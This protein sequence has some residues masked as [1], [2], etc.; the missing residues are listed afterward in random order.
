MFVRVRNIGLVDRSLPTPFSTSVL[1]EPNELAEF[2]WNKADLNQVM[3]L[4][5]CDFTVETITQVKDIFVKDQSLNLDEVIPVIEECEALLIGTFV[6]DDFGIHVNNEDQWTD[7]ESFNALHDAYEA[8]IDKLINATSQ[9]E[10]SE[11]KTELETAKD[12]VELLPGLI[13][14]NPEIS[15]DAATEVFESAELEKSRTVVSETGDDLDDCRSAYWATKDA[16]DTLNDALKTAVTS[17]S[18]ASDQSA[19]DS[20][21]S[22]LE[23]ALEAFR[24]A[25]TAV[26]HTGVTAP[27]SETPIGGKTVKDLQDVQIDGTTVSGQIHRVEGL[28]IGKSSLTG[29]YLYLT[30]DPIDSSQVRLTNTYRNSKMIMATVAGVTDAVL[31]P[32]VKVTSGLKLIVKQFNNGTKSAVK[33]TTYDLGGLTLDEAE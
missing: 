31:I 20:A 7:S 15:V 19:V 27:A 12:A 16:F 13:L 28:Q 1:L 23:G 29:Y 26:D 32:V 10:V 30:E 3:A 8:A 6:C 4:I 11:V 21:V 18:A 2:E 33:E 17:I 9:D 24:G 22:T 14:D 5:G 25:R